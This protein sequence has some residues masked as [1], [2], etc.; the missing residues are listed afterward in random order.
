[1]NASEKL[2]REI[3]RVTILQTEYEKLDGMPNV[4]VR[5]AVIMM[6]FALDRACIAAGSNDV[7]NVL[8]ALKDLEGFER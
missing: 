8:A 1:M 7:L 6:D 3:R 5:P 4:I 2:A